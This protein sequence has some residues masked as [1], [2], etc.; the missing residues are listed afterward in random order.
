LYGSSHK[1]V[2]P[3][4]KK[5]PKNRNQVDL[6]KSQSTEKLD[7]TLNPSDIEKLEELTPDILQQ[8]YDQ[9][10]AEK[11]EVRED[12]SDIIAEHSKKKRKKE[13]KSNDSK[14]KKYKDFKF[15]I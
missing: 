8:K 5:E 11:R 2:I 4:E 3:S 10:L 7:I 13:S 14:S 1:Y 15:K 6:I 12:V 9:A